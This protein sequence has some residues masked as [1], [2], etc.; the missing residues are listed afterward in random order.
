VD[1]LGGANKEPKSLPSDTAQNVP[2]MLLWPVCQCSAPHPA[3]CSQRSPDPLAVFGGRFAARSGGS[4]KRGDGKEGERKG[5]EGQGVE[6]GG[7]HIAPRRD[8]GIGAPL[9]AS[10]KRINCE[11]L[12]TLTALH[13]R[14]KLVNGSIFET[15]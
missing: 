8:R 9:I 10:N 4:G 5:E 11:C 12:Y 3:G 15:A 13:V 14:Q 2:K 1:I 7:W 6:E